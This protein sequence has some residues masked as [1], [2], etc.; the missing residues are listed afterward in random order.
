MKKASKMK[1]SSKK[2]TPKKNTPKTA[3]ST[4]NTC[5]STKDALQQRS[6]KRQLDYVYTGMVPEVHT[7]YSRNDYGSA[8]S[9]TIA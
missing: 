7:I 9:T 3:K 8:Y 2:N 6:R 5:P 4:S 1:A